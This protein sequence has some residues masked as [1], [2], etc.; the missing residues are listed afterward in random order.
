MFCQSYQQVTPTIEALRLRTLY[1]WAL[2]IG[3]LVERRNPAGTR[4]LFQYTTGDYYEYL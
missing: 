4:V 3:S 1:N 2:V